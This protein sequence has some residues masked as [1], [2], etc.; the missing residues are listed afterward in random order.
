MTALH[1]HVSSPCSHVACQHVQQLSSKHWLGRFE[2]STEFQQYICKDS[3]SSLFHT[4]AVST[5]WAKKLRCFDNFLGSHI[6]I[7]DWLEAGLQMWNLTKCQFKNFR[8]MFQAIWSLLV[9]IC[10]DTF[11]DLIFGSWVRVG[12]NQSVLQR[13]WDVSEVKF[14][15][16]SG[17]KL[18]LQKLFRSMF[19]TLWRLFWH[20]FGSQ[21]WT[22]CQSWLEPGLISN[23]MDEMQLLCLS[24]LT[25]FW[26]S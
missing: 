3:D 10:F 12:L 13:E 23:G 17:L 26:I 2:G 20:F 19:Q 11:L 7:L 22:L 18:L 8:S 1:C 15:Q 25:L 24:F 21:S 16:V 6:W 4:V 9:P 5:K 14:D